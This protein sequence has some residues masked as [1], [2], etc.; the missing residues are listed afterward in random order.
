MTNHRARQ[1]RSPELIESLQQL[2]ATPSVSSVQEKH[3]QSNRPIIDLLANWLNDLGFAVEIMPLPNQPDKA[4]LIATLGTGPG[5]LILS[6]HTDTVPF[7]EQYWRSDP[8]KLTERDNK[9]YGLGSADMKSFMGLAIEAVKRHEMNRLQAPLILLATA[10][11]ESSMEGA[12][13]LVDADRPKAKY[14]IIG[15]PT[16]LKPI[17]A[18][19]GIIMESI[20]LKGQSGHSSDPDLGN[21]AMEGMHQVIS[22]ILQWRHELQSKYHDPSFVVPYPTLN[23]GHIHGGDNP[24]RICGDCDLHID[25]RPLPGMSTEELRDELDQRIQ[26]RLAESNFEYERTPLIHGTDPMHTEA[27]TEIVKLAEELT[28]HQAESVAYC[29]E[30][31]YLNSM[32]MQ[33]IIM[34]PGH[35]DQA[36]QPDEYLPMEQI[37]PAIV[38]I[39]NM[40]ERTCMRANEN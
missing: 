22:E 36:H 16:G 8:F 21:N 11:E 24:N 20:R 38:L 17:R 19:K 3:D 25:L 6:G 37:E 15:E 5:G 26:A 7:N 27:N 32:G 39:G 1:T 30:G 18:H 14:A 4:N 2:I 10:D 12:M 29:T 35:I 13:A 40:I 31:P 23:L 9:L 34:G 33:T 28:G